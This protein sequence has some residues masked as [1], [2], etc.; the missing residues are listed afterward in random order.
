MLH[1][2]RRNAFTSLPFGGK[3]S[4]LYQC[5]SVSPVLNALYL[6]H[7]TLFRCF[8]VHIFSCAAPAFRRLLSQHFQC[9]TWSLLPETECRHLSWSLDLPS[10]LLFASKCSN[11][12]WTRTKRL[13]IIFSSRKFQEGHYQVQQVFSISLLDLLQE[14]STACKAGVDTVHL[15]RPDIREGGQLLPAARLSVDAQGRS[16]WRISYRCVLLSI[17]VHHSPKQLKKRLRSGSVWVTT[18]FCKLADE[19]LCDR[20]GRPMP[21]A[22]PFF[23]FVVTGNRAC[24]TRLLRGDP[25]S[26]NNRK[27]L[28]FARRRAAAAYRPLKRALFLELVNFERTPQLEF[29]ADSHKWSIS[30]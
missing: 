4:P 12:D 13:P 15:H 18:N 16:G 14:P 2:R 1:V 6:Q 20:G 22:S 9:C 23:T 26:H 21:S 19:Q 29:T 11:S 17:C 24:E 28:L 30:V 8:T 25:G 10:C 27:W 3:L 7:Q 5:W